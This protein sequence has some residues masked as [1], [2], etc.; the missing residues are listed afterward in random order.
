MIEKIKMIILEKQL[1]RQR[2]KQVKR[3]LACYDK[4][5]AKP[6]RR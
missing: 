6:E 3:L 2:R 1:V 4:V 5:M